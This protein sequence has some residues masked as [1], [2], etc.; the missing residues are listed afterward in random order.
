MADTEVE[1]KHEYF[2]AFNIPYLNQPDMTC[3]A[4]EFVTSQSVLGRL[5]DCKLCPLVPFAWGSFYPLRCACE[6][7]GAL[8][9][10]WCNADKQ[11][12][13]YLAQKI[14]DACLRALEV[15]ND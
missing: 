11:D 10:L 8:Y 9:F 1:D 2:K 4:C 7:D 6:A 5:Y 13:K 14:A 15:L 12:R 3:Y